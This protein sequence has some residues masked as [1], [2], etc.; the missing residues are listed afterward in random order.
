MLKK[1]AAA[2]AFKAAG[3]SWTHEDIPGIQDKQDMITK[4]INIFKKRGQDAEK[5]KTK[6]T[7]KN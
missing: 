5:E 2:G 3:M 4:P 6:E 7:A 1:A